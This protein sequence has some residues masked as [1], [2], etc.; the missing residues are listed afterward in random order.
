MSCFTITVRNKNYTLSFE[1]RKVDIT[2]TNKPFSITVS[3]FDVT[4]A[5]SG[6]GKM[7][8]GSTFKIK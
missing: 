6:I 7:I 2:V 4:T 5:N 3:C 1:E 8:I